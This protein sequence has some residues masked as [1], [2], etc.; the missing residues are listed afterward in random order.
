MKLL[1]LTLL[2]VFIGRADL[3]S[4]EISSAAI[5]W[6]QVLE[7]VERENSEIRAALK[8]W[9]ASQKRTIQAATP[10]SPRLD[11]ERM[12]APKNQG[13]LSGAEE[14][15]LLI[16]Q[17]LPFPSKLYWR[18]QAVSKE[19]GMAEQKYLS[20]RREVLA[21]ARAN[22][23]TFYMAHASLEILNENIELMRRFAKVA[24]SKYVAGHVGQTDVL[25][26]Q[27]E[28]AKMLSMSVV[29]MQEK[30]VAQSMLSALMGK[31]SGQDLGVPAAPP[32]AK[33]KADLIQLERLALEHRPELL[34]AA[35]GVERAG[36]AAALAR[37]E[38][39][40]DLMFGYRERRMATALSRDAMIGF[41]L[42]LWF[43]GP[44]AMA[45]EAKAEKEMAEA[46]FESTRLMTLSEVRT[47]L[48]R[49]QAAGRLMELY[50][51]G[52]LPQAEAALNVAAANYQ[53]GK[54]GFLDLVDAQRALLNF[55][56]E[57]QQ[58]LAEYE[59]R[60][61]ELQRTIGTEVQ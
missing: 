3:M 7:N 46:E 27:V 33:L 60:L 11:L 22:Y 12:Y 51:T 61:G 52:V 13:I 41:S 18:A 39:L 5:S 19:V 38:F 35:L 8:Q 16:T 54:S 20:K 49:A 17:E 40:P 58:Y 2:F 9:Q 36:A 34:E 21:L 31:L 37:S 53:A 15:N 14:K 26:A 57:Y 25:K 48:I 32:A 30:E 23:A 10:E 44:K 55:K 6:S 42:P 59:I 56:L 29:M 1:F 24:E 50:Q 45:A 28:L 4:A 43:W 47:G